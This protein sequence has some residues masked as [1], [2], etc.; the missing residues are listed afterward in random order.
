[1]N[2]NLWRAAAP[3]SGSTDLGC[4]GGG[5]IGRQ[6]RVNVDQN[7]L[8][9]NDEAADYFLALAIEC[10]QSRF[11]TSSFLFRTDK[12]VHNKPVLLLFVALPVSVARVRHDQHPGTVREDGKRHPVMRQHT[13][14]C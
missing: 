1:M 8:L 10:S 6:M 9:Y 4:G 2:S 3:W 7:L 13:A 11:V 5:A 14:V 12:C